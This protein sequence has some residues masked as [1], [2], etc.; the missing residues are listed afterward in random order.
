M[1]RI[2]NQTAFSAAPLTAPFDYALA[3]GFEAFEW[4]P[5]KK[6]DGAGWDAH[7][8]SPSQRLALR[9]AALERGLRLSLHARWHANP[10]RRESRVWLEEDLA[11]ASSLGATLLNLHL[12]AEAG[13]DDF[14]LAVNPLV[15]ATAAA[16]LQLAFENTPDHA[17][18]VFNEL[19]ARLRSLDATPVGHVGMCF[20]LGHANLCAATRNDYLG[21]L[22]RL[23]PW[24][25]IIHVHLHENWGDADAHLPLFTGPAG[26]DDA[27]IRG[28]L[29][30]LR[31]RRFAGSI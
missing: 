21:F 5:D 19:F 11:L 29:E 22:D 6:P 4:F 25:P 9:A 3:Q 20:D 27:G 15:R 1:I 16:G 7:D 28:L 23:N 30:R 18:E 10:L 2:G 14:L 8:L 24:V 13:L 31:R 17:P 12:W 26:R